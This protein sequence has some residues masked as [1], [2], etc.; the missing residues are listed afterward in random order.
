VSISEAAD[1]PCA[2][3]EDV[4]STTLRAALMQLEV[5]P[6]L[7]W[8]DRGG[9]RV[10][11]WSET[12]GVGFPT[13]G[14]V[15]AN[16]A[17]ARRAFENAV[18]LTA[19]GV[20]AP[21]PVSWVTFGT[22]AAW[23]SE[24]VRGAES[25]EA[26]WLS[27]VH[28]D[29]LCRRMMALLETVAG[30]VRVMHDAGFVHG[31]LDLRSIWVRPD[32]EGG[33]ENAWVLNVESGRFMAS[34]PDA[35]R[36]AD[37]AGIRLPSDME[38]VFW[39]M[40]TTPETVS[41]AFRAAV[42]RA[43][44]GMRREVGGETG[45]VG[46]SDK[47][48]WIWDDRSMQAVPALRSRD[49][50]K[51]YRPADGLEMARAALRYG[52]RIRRECDALMDGAWREPVTLR[53]RVGLSINLEPERF[54]KERK[55]LTPLGPLPLLV[56][57]YHH[58]TPARQRYAVDAVRKLQAEGHRV[59]VAL[60]QDRRAVRFPEKW[61]D[62]VERAGGSL[63]GFVEAFEVC[64]AINRVKWGIWDL[65]EYRNL[66]APFAGWADRYPQIP[67]WGPAGIDFEF[68]RLLP[69]LDQVPE[70]MRWSSFSH[71]MYVDRR[72]APEN[73][74]A[75]YDTVR[76]LAMA[77]AVARVHPACDERVIVSEVNWPLAGTGV[78]SPVGSPYVSPGPRFND[79]S[80]DEETYAAYMVRYVLL[81]LCSGMAERVYWWNLAAHGFG[82][83]DDRAE[84]GWR[85][86]PAY[87]AFKRLVE[88]ADSAT[89]LAREIPERQEDWCLRFE[90]P[91]GEFDVRWNAAGADPH[92][93]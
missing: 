63:S 15:F 17:T 79:P 45:R 31:Q 58:E 75:G 86:R 27:L 22:G 4:D 80:V 30:T 61:A 52:R 78:W 76:K 10:F 33:W 93:F 56:R 12:P 53:G 9:V 54:D 69:F 62:F 73:E 49:K 23:I 26:A 50:R 14:K 67:L 43:R 20:P 5:N 3:A 24:A 21:R 85:P 28:D 18:K 34:V 39:E 68:P 46:L 60:V 57:L 72:G 59:V 41:D 38:R 47:D 37:V 66:L 90:G 44:R 13:V 25:F 55:W 83:I 19:A 71:H 32:G 88:L 7:D 16:A 29:P 91:D 84:T 89:Y 81:A 48:V 2:V 74:Q 92:I 11:R 8:E 77:R 40:M 64:H 36:G 35:V 42:K 65:K 1:F 87:H 51:Y 82:L 70:G 6:A